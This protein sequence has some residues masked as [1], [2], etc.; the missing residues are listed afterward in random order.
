MPSFH[1]QKSLRQGVNPDDLRQR[2]FETFQEK[3]SN[4]DVQK[5]KYGAYERRRQ[6]LMK[7][8]SDEKS[9]L[10]KRFSGDKSCCSAT[11]SLTPSSILAREE[12]STSALFE[13]EERRLRKA[14]E[15]QKK[16]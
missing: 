1:L 13:L 8:A 15:K 9:R 5:S 7:V 11:A 14:K 4:L 16:E 3:N 2:K 10:A 12:A 6:E